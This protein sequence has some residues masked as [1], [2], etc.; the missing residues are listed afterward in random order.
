MQILVQKLKKAD[1]LASA[2]PHNYNHYSQLQVRMNHFGT[3]RFEG[4][5]P[6]KGLNFGLFIQ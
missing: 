1:T 5:R 2:L 4:L 3:N 6:P